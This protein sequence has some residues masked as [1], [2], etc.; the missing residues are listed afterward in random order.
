[1]RLSAL[2]LELL[3]CQLLVIGAAYEKN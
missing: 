2:C 1:V 3:K